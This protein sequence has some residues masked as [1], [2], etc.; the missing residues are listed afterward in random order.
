MIKYSSGS[1]GF[2]ILLRVHGT[3]TMKVFC[4]SA[5]IG[6]REDR[7]TGTIKWKP[8]KSHS[9]FCVTV[10]TG[11]AVYKAF[12]PCI[13]SS[14]IY[15]VLFPNV[16]LQEGDDVLFLHPYPMGAL[17]S[18]LTFLLA[19]RAN[20]SYN[21]YWE[22]MTA[23]HLMHSKWLDVGMELA[24]FHL[25]AEVYRDRRPPAFGEHPEINSLERARE[26]LLE[27]TLAELEGQLDNLAN[28]IAEQEMIDSSSTSL[29]RRKKNRSPQLPTLPQFSVKRTNQALVQSK[30]HSAVVLEP[31]RMKSINAVNT[32]IVTPKSLKRRFRLRGSTLANAQQTCQRL[33]Q[34]NAKVHSSTGSHRALWDPDKPPLFLQEAAHLLSLMSAVAFSTLRNDLEQA[35]SPLIT[36]TPGV[37]FPHVDPD[38][39]TAD[40]RKDWASTRCRTFTVMRYISGW[41]R[42]A[43]DRTL[44]NAARPFRVVGG[45]SDSEIGLL[46][47]ARGPVAKVALVSMWLQEFITRE[48]LAGSTGSVAT[49]VV[50]RLYQFISDGMVGY[51]QARKVAYIPFPFAHARK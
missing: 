8:G 13:V 20:F 9:N 34:A 41:S 4:G 14:V 47:A 17:I 46:Q 18:A 25:Q 28:E 50:S 49:P 23:V 35:D 10:A 1:Y 48:Y 42:T 33:E 19:F 12:F 16:N 6:R 5:R 11:S 27:P 7:T 43:K 45:V 31:T 22:S 36:F 15:I 39:Y 32:T 40:V 21:R 3:F 24:A 30:V 38:A 2:S 51:H 44:Y 29:F 26:R 37:P